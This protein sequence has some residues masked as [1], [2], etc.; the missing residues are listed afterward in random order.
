MVTKSRRESPK[1]EAHARTSARRE[2]RGDGSLGSRIL[3]RVVWWSLFWAD[4]GVD[5]A[6]HVSGWV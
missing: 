4:R 5:P 2:S 3:R 1:F 6:P